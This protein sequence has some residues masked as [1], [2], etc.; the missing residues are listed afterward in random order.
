MYWIYLAIFVLIILTPQV[1]R[2]GFFLLREEDVEA[3]IIFCFG[4]LGFLLYLAKEKALLRVFKEKLH[5]QKKTNIITKDLSDSYS[6]IGE[7]NRK[8][9]IVKEL[10]FH[11]PQNTADTV[12]KKQ[13]DVYKSIIQAVRL[14]SKT[15]SVSLCFVNTATKEIVN[16]AG[17]GSRETFAVFDGEMLLASQKTFWEEHGCVV[18]RSPYQAEHMV[19]FI[20]FPKAT[21]HVEDRDMFMIL[22]SQAL[23]LYCADLHAGRE[24]RSSVSEKK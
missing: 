14:L 10:I 18:A 1:I 2:D 22:A 16:M 9:D 24:Q 23:L 6:Y 15:E 7:M 12:A 20:I 4:L 17:V 13:G 19:A 11:L 5:L 8:F 21:N 3:L